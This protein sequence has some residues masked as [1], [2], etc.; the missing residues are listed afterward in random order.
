MEIMRHIGLIIGILCLAQCGCSDLQGPIKEEDGFVAKVSFGSDS[1]ITSL[2]RPLIIYFKHDMDRQSVQ[3]GFISNPEFDYT[4][5]W[6]I[7]PLCDPADPRCKPDYYLFYLYPDQPYRSDTTYYCILDTTVHG[8]DGEALPERY[9]FEFTT[10]SAR[11]LEIEAKSDLIGERNIFPKS[12]VLWFNTSMELSYL[13][14]PL[15]ALPEIEYDLYEISNQGNIFEYRITQPLHAETEYLVRV[16]ADIRDIW[17]KPAAGIREIAFVT[18]PV[19]VV[20]HYPNPQ[21]IL[22]DPNVILQVRFNTVMDKFITERA[23][24]FVCG[25]TDLFGSFEWISDKAFLF[26]PE[27]ELTMGGAYTFSVDT[28]ALDLYGS[29]LGNEFSYSFSLRE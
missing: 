1:L 19:R 4:P 5:H 14:A 24:S 10:D 28:S 23:F 3:L 2:T 18:D 8:T 7:D 27:H 29:P 9:E 22:K 17:G 26:Y 13:E 25:E 11:L 16:N 21:S 6:T 12:L 15:N 20:Y